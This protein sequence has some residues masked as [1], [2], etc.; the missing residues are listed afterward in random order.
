MAFV[1]GTALTR[2]EINNHLHR[3]WGRQEEPVYDYVFEWEN[4]RRRY[5]NMEPAAEI[6]YGRSRP[7]AK[8][9]VTEEDIVIPPRHAF[10]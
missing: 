3:I 10:Y 1:P 6:V 4:L 9:E 7:K 2:A 5:M 8:D